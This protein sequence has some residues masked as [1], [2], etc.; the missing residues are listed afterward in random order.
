MEAE[1]AEWWKA[2]AREL[3]AWINCLKVYS[4]QCRFCYYH[5]TDDI[6]ALWCQLGKSYK[7]VKE[8]E[9]AV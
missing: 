7:I 9:E 3:A 1:S 6:H 5:N 8:I 2:K 4:D